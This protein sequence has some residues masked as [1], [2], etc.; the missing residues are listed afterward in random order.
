MFFDN[1]HDLLRVAVVGS[2]GYLWLVFL[3]RVSGKRTLSKLNA[4]DLIV[5]V[6][7]GSILASVLLSKDVS[8]AEGMVAFTLL[9]GLQYVV[10]GLSVRSKPFSRLVKSEPTLLAYRGKLLPDQMRKERVTEVEVLQAIRSEGGGTVED[11]AA[12]V[13]E[14]DG[15]FSVLIGEDRLTAARNVTQFDNSPPPQMKAEHVE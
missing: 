2:L 3:V 6:A 14:T 7:I 4:F 8:L 13:L 15:S 12:V 10:A 5:T 11:V 9:I 1:W